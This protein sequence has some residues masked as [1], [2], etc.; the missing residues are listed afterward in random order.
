MIPAVFWVA[1]LVPLV[2]EDRQDR[3]PVVRLIEN[4]FRDEEIR[5]F[6]NVRRWI[7]DHYAGSI[8]AVVGG[9]SGSVLDGTRVIATMPLQEF[10]F[11]AEGVS[12]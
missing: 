7:R 6:V 8:T 3:E 11:E 12:V 9:R 5:R 4:L 2:D 10:M 1:V